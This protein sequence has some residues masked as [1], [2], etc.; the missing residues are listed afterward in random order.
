MTK[1]LIVDDDDAMRRLLRL[2]LEDAYEVLD[3]GLPEQALAL[4]LQHKPDAILLDLRMPSYS[5]YELCQTFTSFN[6]TQMIPVFVISG[7]VGE[8]TKEL[9]KKL[10]AVAFFEKPVD[11]E[12]LR[13]AIADGLKTR[14]QERRGEARVRLRA[15]VKLRVRENGRTLSSTVTTT[16]NVGRNSFLCACALQLGDQAE[17]DVFLLASPEEHAGKARVV[18]TEGAGTEY[19]KYALR[20]E[21]KPSLWVLN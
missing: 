21:E 14:R 18:R 8:K 15:T 1:L 10:G 19:P 11:F 7:E 20:F 4:A 13:V 9:C 2:N 6:S 17:V 3:T 12:R 16:E 5:G